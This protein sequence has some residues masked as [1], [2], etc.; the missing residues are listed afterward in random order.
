MSETGVSGI[1]LVRLV[2]SRK[3]SG[4]PMRRLKAKK[5]EYGKSDEEVERW[6][7]YHLQKVDISC[8]KV[9]V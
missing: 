2:E 1:A 5:L 6:L 4:R 7:E 9:A 3:E 8:K